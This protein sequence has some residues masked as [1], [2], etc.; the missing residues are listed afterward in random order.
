VTIK[1]FSGVTEGAVS[2]LSS[3]GV[4]GYFKGLGKNAILYTGGNILSKGLMF[5]LIP[6]YTRFLTPSDYGILGVTDIVIAVVGIILTLQ[7]SGSIEINYFH[8]DVIRRRQL[9]S[10]IWWSVLTF[11]T[12][13]TLALLLWGQQWFAALFADVPFSPYIQMAVAIG[14]LTVFSTIPLTLFRLREQ[15]V[16]YGIVH[17]AG[18]ALNVSFAIWFVVVEGMGARGVLW[19]WFIANIVQTAAYAILMFKDVSW[20]FSSSDLKASLLLCLPFL[21]HALANWALSL[22]DRAILQAYVSLADLGIYRLAFQ[23]ALGLQI[24]LTSFNNSWMPFFFRCVAGQVAHTTIVRLATYFVLA[25]VMA[26]SGVAV[27]AGDAIRMMTPDSYH[28]T[29]L[30]VPWLLLGI[31]FNIPYLIW[32]NATVAS[33]KTQWMAIG[34]IVAAAVNVVANLLTVPRFGITAAAI[35][36]ALSYF[37]LA[38][39]HFFISRRVLPLPHEYWRWAKISLVAVIVYGLS[40]FPPISPTWFSITARAAIWGLWPLLLTCLGFWSVQEYQLGRQFLVRFKEKS[41]L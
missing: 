16:R 38:L 13:I 9:I 10:T 33:K 30:I 14:Y 22:S 36:T 17:L 12:V 7:L 11:A 4:R 37:V 2:D 25:L 23:L 39:L 20:A 18:F 19:G 28:P 21:P 27:F 41:G 34:T 31:F 15:P 3:P 32:A 6:L 35:N 29:I 8:F 24:L 26:T 40:T 5:L 1:S